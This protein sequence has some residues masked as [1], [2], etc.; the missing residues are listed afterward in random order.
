MSGMAAAVYVSSIST[1]LALSEIEGLLEKAQQ[2][3]REHG[4][5][6]ALLYCNRSFMQYIEGPSVNLA[7]VYK[8]IQADDRHH[9]I[10][11]LFYG[12]I[13]VREF[14]DWSMAYS[15]VDKALFQDLTR[16]SWIRPSEGQL[17]IGQEL[18]RTFW[19]NNTPSSGAN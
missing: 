12:V 18:L 8:K 19:K 3:N 13:E 10:I 7:A 5:T 6:G 15:V 17:S 4:I 11:E 14:L 16:A 9:S 2:R 1:N